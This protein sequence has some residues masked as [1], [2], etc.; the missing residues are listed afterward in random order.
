MPPSEMN[1]AKLMQHRPSDV[2]AHAGVY[3]R[4]AL[5]ESDPTQGSGKISVTENGNGLIA[6]A[7]ALSFYV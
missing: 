3:P 1:A 4:R 5:P 6:A 7:A 2:Y